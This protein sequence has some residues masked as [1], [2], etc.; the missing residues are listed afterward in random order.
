MSDQQLPTWTSHGPLPPL[1]PTASLDPLGPETLCPSPPPAAPADPASHV[2]SVLWAPGC[3]SAPA[4]TA[5]RP[6]AGAASSVPSQLPGGSR[7]FPGAGPPPNTAPR[8]PLLSRFRAPQLVATAGRPGRRQP[9]LLIPRPRPKRVSVHPLLSVLLT[10]SQSGS[11]S[12]LTGRL[13]QLPRRPCCDHPPQS[14]LHPAAAVSPAYNPPT[15]YGPSGAEAQGP[16]QVSARKSSRQPRAQSREVAA[17][18]APSD[19]RVGGALGSM[20][21]LDVSQP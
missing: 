11:A 20:H 4:A 17:V 5:S 10:L 2:P 13:Q 9:P 6:S 7:R 19:R 21:V 14:P 15:P 12:L 8:G 16:E 18:R 3:S 1:P